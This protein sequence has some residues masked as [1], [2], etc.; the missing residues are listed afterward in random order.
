MTLTSRHFKQKLR[1]NIEQKKT[2]Y[3]NRQRNDGRTEPNN[4]NKEKNLARSA[5]LSCHK[6]VRIL[7]IAL[8]TSDDIYM[9]IL[10]RHLSGIVQFRIRFRE[11]ER[12]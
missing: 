9:I 11:R 6:L 8:I 2:T 5:R 10:L 1:G 12:D 4:N 3:A 7:R